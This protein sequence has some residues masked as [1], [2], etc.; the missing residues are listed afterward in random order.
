MTSPA[1]KTSSPELLSIRYSITDLGT[2]GYKT[3]AMGINNTSQVA[4]QSS[5]EGVR[6]IYL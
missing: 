3:T 4:G 1:P 5:K 6:D 2:L